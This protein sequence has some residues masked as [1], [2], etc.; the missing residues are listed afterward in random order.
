MQFFSLFVFR[1]K[2]R[3]SVRTA[4]IFQTVKKRLFTF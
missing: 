1:G 3:Q 4:A 2:W